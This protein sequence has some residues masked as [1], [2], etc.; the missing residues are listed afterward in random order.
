M[1]ITLLDPNRPGPRRHNP[2]PHRRGPPGS[3][4]A[5]KRLRDPKAISNG[6][7]DIPATGVVEPAV[8]IPDWRFGGGRARS[9][10]FSGQPW[11]LHR[12]ECRPVDPRCDR[13]HD[14]A[15][16]VSG[17][18]PR[19][20]R[21][22]DLLRASGDSAAPSRSG[23]SCLKRGESKGRLEAENAPAPAG[24]TP[25]NHTNAAL[26]GCNGRSGHRAKSSPGGCVSEPIVHRLGQHP[27]ADRNQWWKQLQLLYE[28]CR[29]DNCCPHSRK[30]PN[31]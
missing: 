16:A 3:R 2:R 10:Q 23:C 17:G 28:H 27:I 21:P 4:P 6:A 20:R 8:E 12:A 13:K 30:R 9:Y 14:C 29:Y 19:G 7:R 22:D 26:S 15:N 11:R 25:H 5:R 1:R 31:P 24:Y 18:V